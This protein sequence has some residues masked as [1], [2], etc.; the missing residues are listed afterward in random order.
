MK[1]FILFTFICFFLTKGV[2]AV[3]KLNEVYPAPS[4]GE[5]EW[6]ELY[7][8]EDKILDI[9][10]YQLLDLAGNKIKFSTDSVLPLSFIIATS[11][12][13]L[14]NSGDTVFLKNNL[15]DAIEIAI[16]SGSFDSSKTFVKCPDYNGNWFT[17]NLP[18]KNASNQTACQLLTPTPTSST[19]P[20]P[21]P[22]PTLEPLSL[23]TPSPISYN[24]IFI[25]ETMVNSLSGGN[26]WVELFNNNDFSVSL[27]NWF[28]DDIENEGS[29][30]KL[31]SLEILAKGYA[32][33]EL[34]SSMFNNNGDSVRLL[35]FNKNLKDSFEYSSATQEKTWGRVSFDSDEFCLQ[36]PSKG[37]V[38]N[39][40]INPTA[41]PNL[42]SK[43]T[44]KPTN[45]LYLSVTAVANRLINRS[46]SVSIYRYINTSPANSTI[47]EGEI[48]G[49]SDQNRINSHNRLIRSLSF[50]S[51]SYSL[52]TILSIFL[53]MKNSYEKGL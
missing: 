44:N 46:P 39:S 36:E 6:V 53:R 4:S 41:T 38:N 40:C 15:G 20:L 42:T 18:T 21:T 13:V 5:Y 51:F 16:Y 34:T 24:S 11:S 32:I 49:L 1:L 2:F 52:L 30:P 29:S 7:N 35:D 22:T 31:F 14:N 19:T 8:D 9:S 23:P 3:L 37:A 27:T 12:S 10:Q 25:S 50:I 28:I 33:F 43:P 47:E 26:E 17:L 45:P 48:L